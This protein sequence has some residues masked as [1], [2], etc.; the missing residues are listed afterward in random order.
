M[1]ENECKQC[2]DESILKI[3]LFPV[4]ILLGSFGALFTCIYLITV[5]FVKKYGGTQ[6]GSFKRSVSFILTIWSIT[7]ILIQTSEVLDGIPNLVYP[8]PL[9]IDA[10]KH[11]NLQVKSAPISCLATK[12]F[13]LQTVLFSFMTLLCLLYL[14][15]SHSKP[16]KANLLQK[17]LISSLFVLYG[18]LSSQI[19]KVFSYKYKTITYT[20]Y[21][22]MDHDFKLSLSS[23]LNNNSGSIQV[24]VSASQPNV[25]FL[26]SYHLICFC[27]AILLCVLYMVILPI[28]MY[29]STLDVSRQLLGA[30]DTCNIK[31]P[32]FIAN[33]YS[34][35][36]KNRINKDERFKKDAKLNP[37]TTGVYKTSHSLFKL[38]DVALLLVQSFIVNTLIL[39]FAFHPALSVIGCC[40]IGFYVFLLVKYKP[41]LKEMRFLFPSKCMVFISSC[42]VLITSIIPNGLKS[43]IFAYIFFSEVML[44]IA[45]CLTSYIYCLIEGNKQEQALINANLQHILNIQQITMENYDAIDIDKEIQKYIRANTIDCPNALFEGCGV[46]YNSIKARIE[47]AL[48]T[49][50]KQLNIYNP[51]VPSIFIST[52][53]VYEE[54]KPILFSNKDALFQNDDAPT[55]LTF[56]PKVVKKK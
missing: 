1:S 20:D 4:L 54:V 38:V 10:F 9:I 3:L 35:L 56:T 42:T 26:E 52:R 12:P 15:L 18:P 50:K 11:F 33:T 53:N 13:L 2:P 40:S 46:K 55:K 21:L 17:F 41:H 23:F 31:Y 24:L 51:I 8:L 6:V 25:F 34:S 22:L 37:F 14:Y 30:Y 28:Y 5:P 45:T 7:Q 44:C 19:F 36:I 39:S 49:S 32:L 27:I 47:Y 29:F 48:D 43:D 16:T